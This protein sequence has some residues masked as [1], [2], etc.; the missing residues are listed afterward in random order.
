MLFQLVYSLALPMWLGRLL[1]RRIAVALVMT[2]C[3]MVFSLYIATPSEI[4]AFENGDLSGSWPLILSFLTWSVLLGLSYGVV[5]TAHFDEAFSALSQSPWAAHMRDLAS[6]I[7]TSLFY[8]ATNY[9]V[10]CLVGVTRVA[11]RRYTCQPLLPLLTPDC[12]PTGTTPR[13][14][15]ES[16]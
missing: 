13:L 1:D 2:F 3:Q 7:V 16:A 9:L 5:E 8:F 6:R 12:W 14:V 10:L 11:E 15:Y 4:Q